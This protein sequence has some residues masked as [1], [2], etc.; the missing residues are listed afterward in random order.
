M[1]LR[2]L[3]FYNDAQTFL[4]GNG[5]AGF[6]IKE[7][8]LVSVQKNKKKAIE[9]AV[10]HIL[11][12]MVRCAFKYGAKY[13]DCY[14]EFLANYYMKSG[15]IVVG[16]LMFDDL[17]DNPSDWHK[18]LRPPAAAAASARLPVRLRKANNPENV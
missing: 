4:I 18:H 8:E 16:K 10:H 3:D 7:E 2:K 15:F 14:G 11:P 6:A 5:V 17:P 9:T 12:K 13:G 1:L